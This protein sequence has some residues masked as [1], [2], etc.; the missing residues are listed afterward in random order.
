MLN[1][2]F[3]LTN[4]FISSFYSKPKQPMLKVVLI[5]AFFYLFLQLTTINVAIFYLGNTKE[6]L[7]YNYFISN[8]LVYVL[9]IYF[10]ISLVFHYYEYG[11]LAHLPIAPKQII[12]SK[13]ASIILVP[14][15]VSAITQIPTILLLGIKTKFNE[16]IKLVLIVPISNILT[17][18]LILFI[19]SLI[20]SLRYYFANKTTYLVVN[21]T[22]TFLF[23]AI[24]CYTFLHYVGKNLP[25]NK[26]KLD[27][28]TFT[29]LKHSLSTCITQIYEIILKAP[30]FGQIL[31]TFTSRNVSF[32]LIIDLIGMILLSALLYVLIAKI[33]SINYFK[34]GSSEVN[35]SSSKKSK[36]Y[37][38]NSDW[39]NFLQREL[40]V[41]NTEAYFK[42]QLVL[43]I[44]LS[45]ILTLILL[46]SF[47]AGW[48]PDN[49]NFTK[50]G[51]FEIYFA[52]AVLMMT[53][54]NNTSGTPYSREGKYY[55][56]I[57]SL[58]LNRKKIYFSKVFLASIPSVIAVIASFI[59]F[60]FFGYMNM[61]TFLMMMIVL[62][63]VY[64]YN[65]LTPIY[66]MLNPS[67]EW[68]NPSEAVKS[69]PN[70]L[71]S[72]LFGLPILII[73][74]IIHFILLWAGL[75]LGVSTLAIFLITVIVTFGVYTWFSKF[76]FDHKVQNVK[77]VEK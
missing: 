74:I 32:L 9:V 2:K 37:D 75:S 36:V 45:P 39:A 63:L 18:L 3:L 35:Q 5:I 16:L 25:F 71:V 51:Y 15:I 22:V 68:E 28:T 34:T 61:G 20:N 44:V 62:M 8:L 73:V 72:L 26:L 31:Y 19:L 46:F 30:F 66:D 43:G 60:M 57:S 14:T 21:I 24:L 10:S 54:I 27:F 17:I 50:P 52:Y 59:I 56:L 76:Y 48:V 55:N 65:L 11:I 33:I 12:I 6:F 77:L 29:T 7:F 58:P 67:I 53:C 23:T 40:W 42:M 49:M 4:F 1:N 47:K 41:M 38:V 70:V 69:N 64:C 13:I